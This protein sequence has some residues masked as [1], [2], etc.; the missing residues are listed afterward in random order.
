[1]AVL[2]EFSAVNVPLNSNK[3]KE[4]HKNTKI[5]TRKERNEITKDVIGKEG[6]NRHLHKPINISL[7]M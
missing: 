4:E 5:V 7:I 2:T 1:M 3:R 6:I